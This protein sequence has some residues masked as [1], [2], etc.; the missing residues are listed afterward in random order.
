M[1]T[2]VDS[3]QTLKLSSN[4]LQLVCSNSPQILTKASNA[5]GFFLNKNFNNN[6]S[7]IQSDNQ[8]HKTSA[9]CAHK[10]CICSWLGR[11]SLLKTNSSMPDLSNVFPHSIQS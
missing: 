11:I 8:H 9:G 4:L 6:N 10:V 1:Q 2:L 3:Y 5:L 7:Y